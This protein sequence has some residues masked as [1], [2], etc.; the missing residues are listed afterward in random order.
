MMTREEIIKE[1][2]TAVATHAAAAKDGS[3][4]GSSVSVIGIEGRR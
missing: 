2:E 4:F 1:Y 3:R